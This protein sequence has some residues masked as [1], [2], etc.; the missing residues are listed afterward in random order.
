MTPNLLDLMGDT[1]AAPKP[2][3]SDAAPDP[4]RKTE[5]VELEL[6]R[7]YRNEAKGEILVSVDGHEAKAVWLREAEIQCADTGRTSPATTTHGKRL[8]VQLPV[9]AVNLPEWLAK[10]KGLI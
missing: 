6:V 3:S 5:H 2:L 4:A 10:E 1:G 9:V 7:H 8:T